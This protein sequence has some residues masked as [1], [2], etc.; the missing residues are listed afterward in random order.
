M[1]GEEFLVIWH[2]DG[3]EVRG[4]VQGERD[5]DKDIHTLLLDTDLT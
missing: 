1:Q 4:T 5:K 2:C 3:R